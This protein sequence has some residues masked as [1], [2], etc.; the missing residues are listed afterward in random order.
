M[1]TV[2]PY[3]FSEHDA[4]RTIDHLDDLWGFLVE[5]RDPSAIAHL[6]PRLVGDLDHDLAAAWRALLAAGSALRV[7]GQLP[8]TARGEVAGLFRSDGGVPKTGADHVDVTFGGV[9]GDRQ[10]NRKHHG[11][12]FQALCIWS[13]DV[14]D[15]LAAQGHPIAYGSAGENITVRGLPWDDV[16]PGVRLAIGGV[17]C[18]VSSYAVPCRH[19]ARWFSDGNYRRIAH[20]AGPVARVYATVIEQG[21]ISLGDPAILEP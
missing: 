3:T 18:D 15:S 10:G 20:E 11:S 1:R 4:R 7:A 13:A 8:T 19:N 14:I 9:T 21:S 5:R 17:V 2:G 16:R 6:S 12:P